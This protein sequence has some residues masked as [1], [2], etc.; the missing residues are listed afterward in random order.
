MNSINV[1]AGEYFRLARAF[2]AAIQNLY[3]ERQ[4]KR[5]ALQALGYGNEAVQLESSRNKEATINFALCYA[6]S[7][8]FLCHRGIVRTG[9]AI[10]PID[11]DTVKLALH[12]GFYCQL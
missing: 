7:G 9:M 8:A 4:L 6:V 10:E 11:W 3:G 2:E 1:I 12:F 5:L